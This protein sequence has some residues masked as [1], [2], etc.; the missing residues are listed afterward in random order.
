MLFDLWSA[1]WRVS[2]VHRDSRQVQIERLYS[3][4]GQGPEDVRRY[5][6]A[7]S[8]AD[9]S[10]LYSLMRAPRAGNRGLSGRALTWLGH[11]LVVWG[12]RLQERYGTMAEPP[13]AEATSATQ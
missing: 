8:N 9:I 1:E 2:Q 7:Y 11:R 12:S 13:P 4:L 5:R 3:L 6:V 10:W